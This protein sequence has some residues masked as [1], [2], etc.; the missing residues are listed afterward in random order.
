ME[1]SFQGYLENGLLKWK[2]IPPP[3]LQSKAKASEKTHYVQT[4]PESSP[5]IGLE[6]SFAQIVVNLARELTRPCVNNAVTPDSGGCT[7]TG[8]QIVP[9][10]ASQKNKCWRNEPIGC[11]QILDALALG[12]YD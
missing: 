9:F 12:N 4:L 7:P 6:H 11:K 1:K 5:V 8:L 2:W 10:L 3:A